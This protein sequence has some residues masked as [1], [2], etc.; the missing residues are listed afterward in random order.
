MV[1]SQGKVPLP[2]TL[3][4]LCKRTPQLGV[5]CTTPLNNP[6]ITDVLTS[7]VLL[8]GGLSA[9]HTHSD[10]STI[11]SAT[12]VPLAN[13]TTAGPLLYETTLTNVYGNTTQVDFV[14]LAGTLGIVYVTRTT[15]GLISTKRILFQDRD[16]PGYVRA[17]NLIYCPP[18]YF[19]FVGSTCAPCNDIEAGGYYVSVAWQ[20]QCAVTSVDDGGMVS[21]PYETLTIVASK[22]VTQDTI[23]T[24]ICLFTE[25]KEC[26]VPAQPQACSLHSS[27]M[28]L[29]MCLRF[30]IWPNDNLSIISGGSNPVPSQC[31]A[32]DHWPNHTCKA[33][34]SRV[35]YAH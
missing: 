28:P 22:N 19:G 23:Q 8:P 30:S 35:Q 25:A 18:A 27:S 11:F 4:N 3:G 21:E 34:S 12:C 26:R 32:G 16:K 33:Q 9:T 14:E 31:C 10:L 24:G 20:I 17:T 29:P 15:V 6:F 7:P 13:V 1:T 2:A 5:Q